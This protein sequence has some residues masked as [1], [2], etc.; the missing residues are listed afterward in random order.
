MKKI[1]TL[2]MM[3]LMLGALAACSDDTDR[4]LEEELPDT[5]TPEMSDSPYYWNNGQRHQLK[6]VDNKSFLLFY[7]KDK[8]AVLTQL[9]EQVVDTESLRYYTYTLPPEQ[10]SDQGEG[11]EY[12]QHCL[13]AEI[14]AN[15]QT[16]STI[17][18]IIYTCPFLCLPETGETFPLTNIVYV[19]GGGVGNIK[20]IA[21]ECNALLIG[22]YKAVANMYFVGCT[23]NSIGNALEVAN[24]FA[25][26]GLFQDAEPNMPAIKPAVVPNY[27]I[28]P[29]D[30]Q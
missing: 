6:Y 16:I 25:E 17:P 23:K 27:L 12:F 7:E 19:Y 11:I 14:N 22:C 21:E 18:E 8:D 15:Y 2:L 4:L 1:I 30:Y 29:E 28:H 26:S 10:F 20:K 13:S 24:I 3:P 5:R 9:E